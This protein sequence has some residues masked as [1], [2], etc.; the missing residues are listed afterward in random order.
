MLNLKTEAT[1][2]TKDIYELGKSSSDRPF[3]TLSIPQSN[4]PTLPDDAVSA[5]NQIPVFYNFPTAFCQ[6][7]ANQHLTKWTETT[8][9]S[10]FSFPR[11]C[12]YPQGEIK[13]KT[14]D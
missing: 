13:D 3:Y 1:S 6:T 4:L 5:L 14:K 11:N 7:A 8:A 12:L 2:V 10:L 9:D